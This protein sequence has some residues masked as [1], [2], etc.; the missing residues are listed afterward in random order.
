MIRRCFDQTYKASLDQ[1]LKGVMRVPALLLTNPTQ[2]LSSLNLQNYEIV[3][4]EPLH[5]IKGHMINQL[6]SILPPGDTKTKC[7]HL[8]DNCLAKEKKNLGLICGEQ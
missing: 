5:D 1:I 6:P 7:T 2:Q 3:A 8:I 4:S